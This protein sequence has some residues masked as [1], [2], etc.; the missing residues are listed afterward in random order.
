M[1]KSVK[2]GLVL[3]T[4]IS[5]SACS[6]S[7]KKQDSSSDIFESSMISSSEEIKLDISDHF[8]ADQNGEVKITGTTIP[9]AKV[10]IGK[11]I[12]GD[13]TTSDKDGK[14]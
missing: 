9:D 8:Q 6:E 10:K 13:S 12:I 3:F 11:G 14:F 2:L 7:S 5:L 4:T 1:K